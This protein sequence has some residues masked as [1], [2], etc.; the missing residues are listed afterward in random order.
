VGNF[1]TP[2]FGGRA[3]PAFQGEIP[4]PPPSG[5]ERAQCKYIDSM[6]DKTAVPIIIVIRI[7]SS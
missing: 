6:L 5:P 1:E 3:L 2:K 7:C 4:P